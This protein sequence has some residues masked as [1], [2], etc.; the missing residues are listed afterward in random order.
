MSKKNK[1]IFEEAG[2]DI[3]EDT[4]FET[5]L[6]DFLK[7]FSER[8]EQENVTADELTKRINENIKQECNHE[9][10]H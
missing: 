8:L 2:I 7:A 5:L 10:E 1:D 3:N 9:P 6:S 4:D